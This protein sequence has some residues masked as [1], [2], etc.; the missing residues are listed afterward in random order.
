MRDDE[1]R[2]HLPP[3]QHPLGIPVP[4]EATAHGEVAGLLEGVHEKTTF[5]RRIPIEDSQPYVTDVEGD[6]VAED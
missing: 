1:H 2:A 6:R 4:V 3:D 5:R